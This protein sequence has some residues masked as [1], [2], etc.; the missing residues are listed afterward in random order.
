MVSKL[1]G[2]TTFEALSCRLPIIADAVT[3]P[4]PQESQTLRFLTQTGAGIALEQPKRIVSVIQSLVESPPRYRRLL[5][6]AAAH[7][8]PGASDRIA[9]DV[10][11]YLEPASG[12]PGKASPEGFPVY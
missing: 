5:D 1:G 3:P 2:L 6:A 9:R 11:R 4:M 7:G 12:L 10:L 8:R